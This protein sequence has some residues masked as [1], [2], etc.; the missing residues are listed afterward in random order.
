MGEH[1]AHAE[2]SLF[3]H[4]KL[5]VERERREEIESHVRRD[6]GLLFGG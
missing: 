2:L 1:I 6:I 5:A 4:D 3:A